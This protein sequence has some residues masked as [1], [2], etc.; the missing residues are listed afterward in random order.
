MDIRVSLLAMLHQLQADMQILHQQ[1]AGYYSCTPFTRR[2]NKLLDQA[3]RLF[4]DTDGLI[5]T[6]EAI[7]DQDPK[8]PSEKSKVVQAIRIESGQLITLLESTREENT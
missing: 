2:Y 7:E 5:S 8:D 6:F 1:G 3:R 4:T